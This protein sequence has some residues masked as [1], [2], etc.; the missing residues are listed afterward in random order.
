MLAVALEPIRGAICPS[1]LADSVDGG[2]IAS[3]SLEAFA[4]SAKKALPASKYPQKKKSGMVRG[5]RISSAQVLKL[6]A[7]GAMPGAVPVSAGFDHPAGLRLIGVSI[8]GVGLQDGDLLTEAAGQ[9]ASSLAR[10]VGVVLAARAHHSPEISGRFFRAGVFYSITV[11]Q[12][13]LPA[14]VK[15]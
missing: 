14:D 4:D 9:R 12:P 1:V 2:A 6:A 7:R 11:E 8:L 13:Y 3:A 5:I 15:G 10:V